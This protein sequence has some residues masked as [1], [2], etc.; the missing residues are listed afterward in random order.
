MSTPL[1]PCPFGCSDAVT[2]SE[3]IDRTLV[4]CSV[5]LCERS[6]RGEPHEKRTAL[7]LSRWNTRPA[8]SMASEGEVAGWSGAGGHVGWC[9]T[10][11]GR[12]KVGTHPADAAR[13]VTCNGTG[14]YRFP[15]CNVAMDELREKHGHL[16]DGAERPSDTSLPAARGVVSEEAVEAAVWA[17]N[18]AQGCSHHAHLISNQFEREQMRAALSAALS[19]GGGGEQWISVKERMPEVGVHVFVHGGIAK[20][21]GKRWKSL[22][23]GYPISWEVTHWM[24][25][26]K[27]PAQA[28]GGGKP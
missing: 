1:L 14:S 23:S 21:C 18:N 19:Q 5:C 10:C 16:F 27:P 17:F 12:G 22:M 9:N 28:D 6:A 4:R 8:P 15:P 13:C 26:P 11:D 25:L 3:W 7:A 20:W 2:V 24:P